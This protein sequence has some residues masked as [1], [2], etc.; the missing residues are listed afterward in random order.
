MRRPW[1]RAARHGRAQ[2]PSEYYVS[3]RQHT[4][5]YVSIRQHTSAY[6][7]IRQHTTCA[8]R[9][10]S[11]T[12]WRSSTPS[13]RALRVHDL[14]MDTEEL[15]IRVNTTSAYVSIRQHT[16]AYVSIRPHTSSRALRVHDLQMD[17]RL[18]MSR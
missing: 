17:T 9:K 12:P 6:V 3:I 8:A 16:S 4:S 10:S 11:C 2:H 7:S 18:K 14:Q 13:S 5:A 1:R 15:S